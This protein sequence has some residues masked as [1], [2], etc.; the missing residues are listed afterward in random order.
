MIDKLLNL[1]T[2]ITM[3]SYFAVMALLFLLVG[4]PLLLIFVIWELVPDVRKD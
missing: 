3:V 1:L 2:I 4:I